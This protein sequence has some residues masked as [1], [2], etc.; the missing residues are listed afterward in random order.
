MFH[1]CERLY[2]IVTHKC[3]RLYINVIHFKKSDTYKIPT[4][5]VNIVLLNYND[6]CLHGGT[7]YIYIYT[8]NIYVICVTYKCYEKVRCITHILTYV[9][10][11][12]LM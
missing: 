5:V 3:K 10:H 11:L 2:I 6:K 9:I 8:S 7:L 12:T 1:I 4:L